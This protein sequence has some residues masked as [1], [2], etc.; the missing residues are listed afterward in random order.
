MQQ[1]ISAYLQQT[2]AEEASKS[3]L[4]DV[5]YDMEI[6]TLTQDTHVIK[7]FRKDERL[8]NL[9]PAISHMIRTGRLDNERQIQRMKLRWQRA[10]RWA[11]WILSE[12]EKPYDPVLFDSLLN[13]GD[14]VIEDQRGAHRAKLAAERVRTIRLEPAIPKKKSVWER[15]GLR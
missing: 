11:L 7:L 1:L 12:E 14:S 9:I 15:L 13:F 8:R 5:T 6:R 4:P 10:V 2:G 3:G